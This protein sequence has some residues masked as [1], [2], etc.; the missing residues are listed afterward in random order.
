M[1]HPMRTTIAIAALLTIP[2][3]GQTLE[4]MATAATP[5]Q[6]AAFEDYRAPVG[7]TENGVLRITLDVGVASWQPWGK[8]GPTL[9]ANVFAADGAPPRIPGPLI[10]VTA[11]TPVHITLR[12]GLSD[13]IVVR[14][15]RDRSTNPP[16]GQRIGA[17]LSE[18]VEVAPRGVAEIRFTPTSPGTYFYFGSVYRPMPD[19]GPR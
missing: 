13:S 18:F 11:G 16:P 19:A 14:G 8:D 3:S 1:E 15:L 2:A 5:L 10:R 9:S 12:N 6:P 17:F 4:Q 7:R